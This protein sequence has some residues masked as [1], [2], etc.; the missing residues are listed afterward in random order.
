MAMLFIYHLPRFIGSNAPVPNPN[1][2]VNDYLNR[3]IE[4]AEASQ[5]WPS[6]QRIIDAKT[7]IFKAQT[8]PSGTR[9]FLAGLNQEMAGQYALAISSYQS[10]LGNPDD[11]LP[12]KVVG[13]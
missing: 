4:A 6:L 8:F 10:A 5:D 7:K 9:S 13:D 2:T 3:S 11:Y 1:E 12:A